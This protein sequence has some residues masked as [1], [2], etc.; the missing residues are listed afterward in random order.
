MFAILE[1]GG[2]R[3]VPMTW[4]WN[5]AVVMCDSGAVGGCNG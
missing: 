1:L 5:V 4:V 3:K 2:P